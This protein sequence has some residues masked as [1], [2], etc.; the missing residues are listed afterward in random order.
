VS[1]G[2]DDVSDDVGA[3]T[4]GTVLDSGDGL[5]VRVHRPDDG[6]RLVALWNE[7]FA[8]P[9]VPARTLRDWNW[10]FGECPT[11]AEIV[12]AERPETGELVAHYGGIPVRIHVDGEVRR[13]TLVV[14]SMVRSDHRAGLRRSGAFLRVA[15]AYLEVYG[16]RRGVDANYGFPN[17]E[18]QRIGSALLRYQ[19]WA[20]Q[21]PVRSYAV[22]AD[23]DLAG[24]T[25]IDEAGLAV[26]HVDAVPADVDALWPQCIAPGEIGLVRDHAHLHWR[27]DLSPQ[28]PIVVTA[29]DRSATLR[30]LVV[31]H[32]EWQRQP[33]LAVSELVVPMSEPGVLSALLR[34]ALTIARKL[35][36]GRVEIWTSPT[37][38]H[39]TTLTRLG[40][41]T[42]R[43][44]VRTVFR[45]PHHW[46]E[47]PRYRAA[48]RFA[49]GDSD[50]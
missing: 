20:D 14:D 12:V 6:A 1:I 26:E 8:G 43:S 3:S 31:L 17:R 7:V 47:V 32:P 5:V 37:D 19:T 40:F 34:R 48:W 4:A 45:L 38:P 23:P 15:R 2:R 42:E 25:P 41:A 24:F 11:G 27:H 36:Q 10:R 30:G 35:R 9:S 28:R 50:I 13:A 49:I 16:D 29:R 33:I 22:G 39:A 18:A 46:H 21:M 44:D